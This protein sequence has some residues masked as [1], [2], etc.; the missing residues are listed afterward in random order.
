MKDIYDRMK[1][2][3]QSQKED[4]QDSYQ[5]SSKKRLLN[6]IAKKLTT[7]FIG[8][9]SQIEQALGHL[10]GHNNDKA[11]MTPEQKKYKKIWESLRNKILNN[12]NN[13]LRAIE[14]ELKQY[15]VNWNRYHTDLKVD[16]E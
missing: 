16:N 12:G 7:T 15:T 14:N 11:N 9:I 1:E 4:Y 13:Q 5:E 2:E 3:S 10:W 8:D 6:I